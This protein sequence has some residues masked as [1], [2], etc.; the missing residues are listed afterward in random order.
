VSTAT[1]L[2]VEIGPGPE[3]LDAG[4]TTVGVAGV[5]HEC[6]WGMQRLPFDDNTVD[7]LYAA[8]VIEHIPWFMTDAALADACRV[9]KPGGL[10]EIHTV[11]FAYIVGCYRENK[12]GDD[13][14]CRGWNEGHPL[15]WAASRVMAYGKTYSDVN[16]HKALF[17]EDY[18]RDCLERTGFTDTERVPLPRGPEKHGPINLGM[19]AVK[20]T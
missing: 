4:W 6:H 11:D 8:H 7:E 9:L 1:A 19:K 20:C 10:I 15:K 3:K 5:D 2:R 14:T 12:R 17:D 13:W 16:W 18:L